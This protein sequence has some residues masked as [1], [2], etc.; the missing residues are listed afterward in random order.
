M[1]HALLGKKGRHFYVLLRHLRIFNDLQWKGRKLYE[2]HMIAA[3]NKFLADL[4]L[5]LTK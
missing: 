2:N 5:F 1:F 4:V 3:F